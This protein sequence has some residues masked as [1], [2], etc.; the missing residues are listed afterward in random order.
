VIYVKEED[1]EAAQRHCHR[2]GGLCIA[3]R[4]DDRPD[5]RSQDKRRTSRRG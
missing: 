4:R 2:G 1:H 3:A 5:W